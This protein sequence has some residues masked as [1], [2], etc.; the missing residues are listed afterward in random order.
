M[1]HALASSGGFVCALDVVLGVSLDF[2][3]IDIS[4]TDPP[5]FGLLDGHEGDVP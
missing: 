5:L 4:S 2:L 3:G 1:V